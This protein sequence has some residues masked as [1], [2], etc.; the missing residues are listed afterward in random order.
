M[1]PLFLYGAFA[2]G[3]PASWLTRDLDAVA[4][5]VRGSLWRLPSGEWLVSLDPSGGWVRGEV[6]DRPAEER[7]RL[8]AELIGARTRGLTLTTTRAR[9]GSRALSVE[10]W[11]AEP[12]RLRSLGARRMRCGDPHTLLPGSS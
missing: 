6:V 12:E 2:R 7:L 4:A 8:M 1:L 3:A 5:A 9:V 11:A 10:L